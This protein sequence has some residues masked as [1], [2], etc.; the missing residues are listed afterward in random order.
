M[1]RL[2]Y[3]VRSASA[4]PVGP[5]VGDS[6]W[7]QVE[8]SPLNGGVI[9]DADEG[10][11]ACV[12]KRAKVAIVGCGLSKDR[13][14]YDDPE[15]EVWLLNAIPRWDS[16]HRLRADRYWEMHTLEVQSERDL[17]FLH[18]CPIPLYMPER[19]DEIPSAVRFP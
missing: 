2:R 1:L 19:Y 11:V 8:L 9:L 7:S 12:P 14:P 15:W 6:R 18:W 3:M 4:W 13:T 17:D 5:A 10:H 16:R